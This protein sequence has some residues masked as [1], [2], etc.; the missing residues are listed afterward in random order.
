MAY[1]TH[2]DF[3]ASLQ[4]LL[5]TALRR[6]H[7]RY[8][9]VP[10]TLIVNPRNQDDVRRLLDDPDLPDIMVEVLSSRLWSEI[11]MQMPEKEGK[12]L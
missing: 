7:H 11:R 8:K 2:F 6:Y 12:T 1:H 5:Q 3:D 4:K 10:T 9:A